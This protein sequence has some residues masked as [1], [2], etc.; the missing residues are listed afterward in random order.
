MSEPIL[1]INLWPIESDCF[2]CGVRLFNARHGVPVFEDLILPSD[3]TGEWFGSDACAT[4]YARQQE[5]I[6]PVSVAKWRESRP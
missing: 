3:W 1:V 2:G 5:I 4:C 6:A